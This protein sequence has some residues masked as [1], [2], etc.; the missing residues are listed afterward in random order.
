M[1]IVLICGSRDW[2]DP[3]DIQ[4]YV[5]QHLG[6]AGFVVVTGGAPG[7]DSIAAR[8]CRREGIHV[9]E[10]RALWNV[11]DRAAGPKRNAAMLALRPSRVVAFHP[12][13]RKSRGTRNCIRQAQDLGIP[14][15][16]FD[17]RTWRVM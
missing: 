4:E 5:W 10:V 11:Y 9:A 3:T 16:L 13:I 17:G 7:V 15:R 6:P 8:V 2:T 12:D 14:V 1:R